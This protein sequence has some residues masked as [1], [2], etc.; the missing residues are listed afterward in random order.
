MSMSLLSH[1]NKLLKAHL[2]DVAESALSILDSKI[3][4]IPEIHQKKYSL[5]KDIIRQVVYYSAIFHDFGKA[6]VYFQQ[7]LAGKNET[8]L[9]YHAELSSVIG[10]YFFMKNVGNELGAI[11]LYINILKHHGNLDNYDR[12]IEQIE[13]ED[14]IEIFLTQLSSIDPVQ[15]RDIYTPFKLDIDISLLSESSLKLS[16]KSIHRSFSILDTNTDSYLFILFNFIF[17]ILICSDKEDA[18]FRD[19]KRKVEISNKIVPDIVI[20]Y[21]KQ[22]DSK[23]ELNRV[24][25][26]LFSIADSF[27]NEHNK[28]C[29]LYSLNLPTGSGKTLNA[30]NI[31][32]KL[33]E[34]TSPKG[35]II[36]ALPFTSIID[37]NYSVF[38]KVLEFPDNT[39]LLKHHY[40]TTIDYK[41]GKS[42]RDYDESRFLTESWKS[43]LTVTTFY[44]LF[45]TL[46]TAKNKYL[47]KYFNLI[48]SIIIIDEVQ[49]IPTKYFRLIAETLSALV[50]YFHTSVIISTATKPLIFNSPL[51]EIVDLKMLEQYRENFNRYILNYENESRLQI[52]DFANE[53]V[54]K[55]K[56]ENFVKILVVMN[57]INSSL[58]LYSLLRKKISDYEFIYLSTNIL[59][60]HR[61]ERIQKIMEKDKKQMI[62]STQLIEAGVDIDMDIVFRD[63]APLDS[64]IQTAGRANRNGEKRQAPVW[65]F[66]LVNEKDKEFSS[67]IYDMSQRTVTKELIAMNPNVEEK[68]IGNLID[69]YYKR[70]GEITSS[71]DSLKLIES[72]SHFNYGDVE[73][74]F[75]LI[76]GFAKIDFFICID[77]EA[78]RIRL[79]YE[80]IKNIHDNFE[81]KKKYGQ[82][83][84]RFQQY[85]VSINATKEGVQGRFSKESVNF[86]DSKYYNEET[87]FKFPESSMEFF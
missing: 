35:R 54:K 24:R 2:S 48:N 63:F 59:P 58:E 42:A 18:I 60:I 76:Q 27:I 75:E 74:K 70:I 77:E 38:E 43:E 12:M 79:E 34:K 21:L 4:S 6:T 69:S 10:Y 61:K 51:L 40:S 19:A 28:Y 62:V 65:I 82:L 73:Q 31:A 37:Q 66:N 56:G 11:L 36:Y 29:S 1:P 53:I 84:N 47:K 68:D 39:V 57:T 85:I 86:V 25:Q 14:D 72:I 50:T 83:Q 20:K 23:C 9:A 67:F 5:S 15:I 44:Q 55:I 46:F 17:S 3:Y 13:I 71:Q 45:H 26:E 80:E 64:I 78:E 16:V 22:F 49:A 41:E 8:R 7:H 30:F 33:R 87:G 81:R 32:L 52:E